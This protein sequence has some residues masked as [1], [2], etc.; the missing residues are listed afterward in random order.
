MHLLQEP[1]NDIF[2]DQYILI[3]NEEK[4]KLLKMH[5]QHAIS[6]FSV[7]ESKDRNASEKKH[8]YIFCFQFSIYYLSLFPCTSLNLAILTFKYAT[9]KLIIFLPSFF[10]ST[11]LLTFTFSSSVLLFFPPYLTPC[12]LSYCYRNIVIPQVKQVNC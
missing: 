4:Y 3:H 10:P 9:Y 7:Q 5:L 1:F 6:S 2:V 11:S 8:H 12:F